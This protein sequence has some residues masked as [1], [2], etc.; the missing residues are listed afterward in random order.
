MA[1]IVIVSHWYYP[2]QGAAPYRIQNLIKFFISKQ[3]EV[4][5]ITGQEDAIIDDS[6]GMIKMNLK[7]PK[8]IKTINSLDPDLI[9]FSVPPTF[10][11]VNIKKLQDIKNKLI[12]DIRDPLTFTYHSR[13]PIK[14]NL[15]WQMEKYLLEHSRLNLINSTGIKDIYLERKVNSKYYLLPNGFDITLF[16]HKREFTGNFFYFG[17]FNVM[18]S[19]INFY[20]FFTRHKDSI[21]KH[22]F[23]FDF[24]CFPST[25][26]EE[27]KEITVN[28]GFNFIHFYEPIL[29][30]EFKDKLKHYSI[31]L[32]F[33]RTVYNYSMPSKF[34]THL[35][36][37]IPTMN[38]SFGR[39]IIS[40]VCRK[41]NLGFDIN[42]DK[43]ENNCCINIEN[44]YDELA[45]NVLENRNIYSWQKIVEEFYNTQLAWLK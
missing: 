45:K 17:A 28:E 18:H 14:K 43:E 20:K 39:S 30:I 44:N 27:I 42:P 41:Y 40:Q 36:L 8:L 6:F 35:A 34:Y 29:D 4:I 1:K 32:T 23:T 7:N 11:I 37:G 24:Y 13:N 26:L 5:L 16:S 21:K 2:A 10:G 19:T 33:V 25:Q 31:G 22:D 9:F 12:F 15:L 38:I 3:H